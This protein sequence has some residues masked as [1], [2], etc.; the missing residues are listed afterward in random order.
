MTEKKSTSGIGKDRTCSTCNNS[1]MVVNNR[2]TCWE[3]G[4][5][6]CDIDF[7]CNAHVPRAAFVTR[8]PTFR[9]YAKGAHDAR[10]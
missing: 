3:W 8:K 7:S 9:V 4:V 2:T 1:S 6:E 10:T 5:K